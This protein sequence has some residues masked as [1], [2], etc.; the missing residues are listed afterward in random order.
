MIEPVVS[1]IGTL[2]NQ[3]NAGKRTIESWCRQDCSF[4]Y[5]ILIVD[6]GSTDRSE[7]MLRD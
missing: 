2:Y 3:K 7:E 4:P 1:V 6:D 5:E